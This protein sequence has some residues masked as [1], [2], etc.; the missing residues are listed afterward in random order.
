MTVR[1]LVLTA[2]MGAVIG[3]GSALPAAAHVHGINP[4][5]CTP[6]APQA[7]ATVPFGEVPAE[8]LNGPT[9]LIPVN[10]GGAVLEN[11]N[12]N[13]AAVCDL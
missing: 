6:A 12:A 8:P 5:E 2:A 9:P 11:G 4:L 3:M 13:N 10:A 1:R 7:G